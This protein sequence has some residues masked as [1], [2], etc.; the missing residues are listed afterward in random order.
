MKSEE[1]YYIKIN[2]DQKGPYTLAHIR[3]LY[4]AGFIDPETEY[5]HEQLEQWQ[6][7]GPLCEALKAKPE[8]PARWPKAILW[9]VLAGLL[10]VLAYICVPVLIMGWKEANQG[11]STPR[12]AYWRARFFV[13]EQ[14]KPQ[15]TLLRFAPYSKDAVRLQ[16][17]RATVVLRTARGTVPQQSWSVTLIYDPLVERW[18]GQSFENLAGTTAD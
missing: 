17:N 5:W 11:G 15:P 3:H 2:G 12:A 18:N 13:R 14:T 8:K 1:G 7:I 6:Q 4:S 16:E 9:L 10:S